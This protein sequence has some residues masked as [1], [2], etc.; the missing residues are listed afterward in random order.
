M[1]IA[2]VSALPL[3]DLLS[4]RGRAGVVT[5]AAKGIGTAVAARLAEAGRHLVLRDVD[6]AGGGDVA[7]RLREDGHPAVA[8]ALDV[9]DSAAVTAAADLCISEHGRLDVWV[10][11]AGIFPPG[12]TLEMTDEDWDRVLVVN[13]RGTFVGAREAARRC[14]PVPEFRI[15]SLGADMD[16]GTVLERLVHPG[17]ALRGGGLVT[18]ALLDADTLPVDELMARLRDLVQRGRGGRLRRRELTDGTVTVTNLGE[19]GAEVVHGVLFPPQVALVG[20]GRP[21]DRPWAVDGMLGIRPVVTATLAADHRATDGHLGSRF[22]TA[23]GHLLQQPDELD[24]RT[25]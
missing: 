8:C 21:V 6:E 22:L 15:P 25:R 23:V 11:N 5:G 16:V 24:R 3:R 18:P 10:N 14:W 12:A 17:D 1:A 7:S 4:L 2:D 13:L 9:A 20:F 19:Q